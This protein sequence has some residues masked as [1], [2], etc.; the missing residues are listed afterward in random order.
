MDEDL[1]NMIKENNILLREAVEKTQDNN[2]RIKNIHAI[3][4]RTFWSKIAYWVLLLLVTAGAF[5]A[6]IPSINSFINQ[7]SPVAFSVQ[8]E[9]NDVQNLLNFFSSDSEEISE[10]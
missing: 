9:A 2:T 8:D 10:E 3:M 6:I 4:K 5:F 7:F 1:R